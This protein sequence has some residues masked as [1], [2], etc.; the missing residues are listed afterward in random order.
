MAVTSEITL[1]LARVVAIHVSYYG[2][3]DSSQWVI[4]FI[5]MTMVGLH[6]NGLDLFVQE[7]QII[8]VRRPPVSDDMK[9]LPQNGVR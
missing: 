3:D 7:T 6:D 8:R 5:E 2:N 4:F 9:I 1:W